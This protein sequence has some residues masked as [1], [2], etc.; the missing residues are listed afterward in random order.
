MITSSELREKYLQ[1]F[2]DRGHA[3]IPSAPL[4]PEND[5]STLFISAGMQPLVPYLLGQEHPAGTRLVNCQKCI[6]TGDIDEVGD[7]FHHTFFEMLGNWSLGDYFKEKS[8]PWSFEFLTKELNIPVEKLSVSV[9][10]GDQDAPRD[11]EAAELW[12]SVGIPG[13]RIYYFGKEDNWWAAGDTGPC[14]PDTEIFYDVTGEP[15]SPDCRPGDNCGRYFEIW[16]NVFMVYNRREDGS[17]EELPKK[18]VDTGMG[19]DRTV[20]VLNGLDDDYKNDLFSPL[21]EKTNQFLLRHVYGIDPRVNRAYRIIADHMRAVTFLISEGVFPGNKDKEYIVRRLIRNAQ[22][23]KFL[24][25]E[26]KES[27]SLLVEPVCDVYKDIYP[28]LLSK[29]TKIEQTIMEEEDKFSPAFE[30]GSKI[31][32]K[33]VKDH[34]VGAVIPGSSV[35]G[36]GKPIPPV[37]AQILFDAYQTHGV[38]IEFMKDLT[39]G[40]IDEKGFYELLNKHQELSRTAS[41]GMFKGGLAGDTPIMRKYHTTAHLLQAALRKVLGEHVEQAGQNITDERLRFDF[42][43]QSALTEDEKKQVE[44]IINKNIEEAHPV[45]SKVMDLEEAYKE[46]ALGFFKDKYGDQVSVYTVGDPEGVWVSK[47]IC[48]G[49]HVDNTDEIGHVTI[50]KEESAGAGIRRIYIQLQ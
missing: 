39:N 41:A 2:K 25:G 20:T 43:H 14:G 35:V 13:E 7:A 12:K 22:T 3:I 31:W 21:I 10:A 32:G 37:S 28:E 34:P 29:K 18:N 6:R 38:P 1:F 47:E 8:I 36:Q 16:N 17:L 44:D 46:G 40:N 27:L 5:A 15:C 4:V 24:W 9:F 23:Q 50:V 42:K 26:Q 45:Y 11:T 30:K 48:G 33:W 19:L 49:P